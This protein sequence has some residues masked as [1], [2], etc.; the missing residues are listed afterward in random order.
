[1]P[2]AGELALNF[3]Q[4]DSA[5]EMVELARYPRPVGLVFMR[6]LA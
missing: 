3:S 2:Q 1:M 4:P 6:H 5:G